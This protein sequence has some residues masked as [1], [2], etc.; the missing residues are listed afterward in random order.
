MEINDILEEDLL[1]M[2]GEFEVGLDAKVNKKVENKS[3]TVKVA[4]TEINVKDSVDPQYDITPSKSS[5]ALEIDSNSVDNFATLLKELLNNKT[6][7]I[8]IK[9]KD[10]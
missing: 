4:T 10:N 7:E 5:R 8:T 2:F 1:N 3:S 6:I 9:I